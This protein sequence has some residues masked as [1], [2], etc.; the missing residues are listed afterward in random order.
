LGLPSS[1]RGG[2]KN[3]G[4]NLPYWCQGIGGTEGRSAVERRVGFVP[5]EIR[6]LDRKLLRIRLESLLKNSGKKGS[7]KKKWATKKKKAKRRKNR[8]RGVGSNVTAI[9]SCKGGVAGKEAEKGIFV[10]RMNE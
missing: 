8:K 2:D 4:G 10:S 3:G 5:G 6:A 1:G 7:R 9:K